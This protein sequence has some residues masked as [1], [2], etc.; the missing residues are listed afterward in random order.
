MSRPLPRSPLSSFVVLGVGFLLG[1][2]TVLPAQTQ[3]LA[4]LAKKER[5]RRAKIA[6]PTKVLVEEDAKEGATG[7]KPGNVTTLPDAAAPEATPAAE[8]E[9][10]DAQKGVWKSR[11]DQARLAIRNAEDAVQDAEK[12][13][14]T[15][16][17]DQSALTAQEAQ[18]PMRL[19]KREAHI[20][21]LV[22]KRDLQ[23]ELLS[24][25]RKAL[26]VLEQEARRRGVPPGWLR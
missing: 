15:Y 12:E 19:Q 8:T 9:N 6:K 25:A 14:E 11:A 2:L 24:N 10:P 3:D 5:E 21:E 1:M 23:K 17:G 20:Q 4:A 13:I 18:D 26:V 16:R 7:A 22:G